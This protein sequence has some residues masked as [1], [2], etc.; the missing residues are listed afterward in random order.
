MEYVFGL[1]IIFGG[2]V[3]FNKVCEFFGMD[4]DETRAQRRVRKIRE[5]AYKQGEIIVANREYIERELN[6]PIK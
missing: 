5:D 2:I 1:A 3:I 6:K 4:L